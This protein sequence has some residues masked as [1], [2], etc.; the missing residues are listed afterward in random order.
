MIRSA[1]DHILGVWN[2]PEIPLRI[3]YPLE[4]MED[5]R[6]QVCDELQRLSRGGRD[7]AGLLFGVSRESMARILACR[8]IS[9]GSPEEDAS[10]AALHDRAE[11]VRVLSVAA[12]D[13]AMRG[14]EPLGW[15]VSRTQG[16]TGL[17][18][19]EIELFNNFF[20]GSW[21]FTLMLRQGP[22]GTARAGF[23]VRD[24]GGGLRPD[25]SYRELL[26]QP[27]RR[28]PRSSVPRVTPAVQEVPP[29]LESVQPTSSA[30]DEPIVAPATDAPAA[31]V[32]AESQPNEQL[33][34]EAPP[35]EATPL[36]TTPP[37]T[38]ALLQKPA[39]DGPPP[40]PA[41]AAVEEIKPVEKPGEPI[42]NVPAE[43]RPSKSASFAAATPP[44]PE[45]SAAAEAPSLSFQLQTH[46][47]GGARWLWVFPLLLAAG[48]VAYLSLQKTLPVPGQSFGLRVSAHG[49]SVE[50]SWD[51]DSIPVRDGK[52]AEIEIQDGPNKKQLS[53]SANELR[54]GRVSYLRETGDVALQMTIYASGNRE[55][56]EFARLVAMAAPPAEAPPPAESPDTQLRAERDGLKIE[57][58]QLKEEVRDASARADRA[59]RV[60]R[61]LENRLSIRPKDSHK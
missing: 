11:L 17:T 16:G 14:L 47:F 7:A 50:I 45:S 51:R 13:P 23:F 48:L 54:E 35:L 24:R 25:A 28:F 20:P 29:P 4:I 5:L 3:E 58:Q 32:S 31:P 30:F 57:V 52:R 56:H 40:E 19:L 39:T 15:F 46:S 59:E 41:P 26:V 55:F 9:R 60:V 44:E 12:T 36:E 21:Q 18:A 1:A 43:L 27:L 34:P 61:I 6:G 53:L 33:I 10:R 37:E 38:T 2:T 8:P 49:D 22:G 42:T